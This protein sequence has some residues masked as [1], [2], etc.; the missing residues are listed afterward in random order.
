M[1]HLPFFKIEEVL[2]KLYRGQ[3][4]KKISTF[5]ASSV[6]L[7]PPKSLFCVMGGSFL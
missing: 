5:E 1:L 2:N 7:T 4:I 3:N 6:V